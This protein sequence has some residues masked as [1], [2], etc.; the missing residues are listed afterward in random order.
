MDYFFQELFAGH[1]QIR[2]RKGV[3]FAPQ[4]KVIYTSTH[5]F[6]A[7]SQFKI[8]SCTVQTTERLRCA[9]ENVP[10]SMSKIF[11]GMPL[12]LAPLPQTTGQAF[13]N[14][15]YVFVNWQWIIL[16]AL[17]WLLGLI[18]LV[19]TIWKTRG[20]MIP[21]WK[22]DAIPLLFLYKRTQ[23]EKAQ[24]HQTLI[25]SQTVLLNESEGKLVLSD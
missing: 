1:A 22:N 15:M 14:M 5:L 9:L 18:P 19:G 12:V 13:I 11:R 16:P 23:G 24:N 10:E 17:V 2:P 6:Q 20:A 25:N 4:E 7:N 8:T 3:E 21:T